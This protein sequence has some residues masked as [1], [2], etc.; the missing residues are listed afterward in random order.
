MDILE[1]SLWGGMII[2]I[3]V[4]I[5]ALTLT[6]FPK[7]TFLALWGIALFR[8]FTPF[9]VESPASVQ[10]LLPL[11]NVNAGALPDAAATV[12]NAFHSPAV[13]PVA[14]HAGAAAL[15]PG[16]PTPFSDISPLTVIWISGVIAFAITFIILYI[17]LRKMFAC[18]LPSQNSYIKCWLK[19]NRLRR[20]VAVKISDR[21]SAPLAY[22]LFHP[23]ILLPKSIDWTD[24]TRLNYILAHE[25]THIKRLDSLWKI[26]LAAVLCMHWFNPL[27]WLLYFLAN[28]DLELACDEAVIKTVGNPS[29]YAL[30][31][32]SME[33]KKS[34]PLA[35]INGFS[36]YAIKERIESIMK[37]KKTSVMAV[38]AAV[39]LV[40]GV[41]AAL[42][43][44]APEEKNV[45][46]ESFEYSARPDT[47]VLSEEDCDALL[48]LKFIL[49]ED[50]TFDN[51]I[52]DVNKKFNED[53]Q[54]GIKCREAYNKIL[55]GYTLPKT[56]SR[57]EKNFLNIIL[58]VT[59]YARIDEEKGV[60][61][62]F[63]IAVSFG[64]EKENASMVSFPI[65]F[66]SRITDR[67]K[68]S[69]REFFDANNRLMND[70]SKYLE[71]LE[72]EGA[73]YNE[74]IVRDKLIELAE[75][76]NTGH[77]Q[78][79]GENLIEEYIP[80]VSKRVS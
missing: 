67:N 39:I 29:S 27:V 9:T 73:V 26:L 51:F 70:I 25:I 38:I 2:L 19:E 4:L 36:R 80:D 40:M 10:N 42:A 53:S 1:M 48:S 58:P 43:S 68:L 74:Q 65:P 62:K 3:V 14:A 20:P 55:S 32:L 64:A 24:T 8:L 57:E 7:N 15:P 61:P 47:V 13:T 72:K 12:Q 30:T 33:E 56:L 34:M 54:Q 44:C 50:M 22:G 79:I 18:A 60:E 37:Y 5:R 76:N 16:D 41:T 21:I 23:V 31:L 6:R 35:L 17:R 69:V 46:E 52:K 11:D 78:F 77:I 66:A 75:K 49:Y 63:N 45:L 59:L 71:S 28:R